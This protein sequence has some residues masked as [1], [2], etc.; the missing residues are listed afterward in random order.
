[1]RSLALCAAALGLCFSAMTGSPVSAVMATLGVLLLLWVL[2]AGAG[3]AG[4]VTAA[5]RFLSLPT[6]LQPF[7]SGLVDT[8][9]AAYFLGIAALALNVGVLRLRARRRA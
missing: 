8:S 3:N 5:T 1:M 7:L 2:G 4:E 9:H 6:H